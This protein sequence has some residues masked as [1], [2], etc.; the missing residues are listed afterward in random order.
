MTA[1]DVTKAANC[2]KGRCLRATEST[3]VPFAFW[4]FSNAFYALRC[5]MNI[6]ELSLNKWLG[7]G[8]GEAERR[9][10]GKLPGLKVAKRKQNNERGG[11]H[12]NRCPA[13]ADS[14]GGCLLNLSA[15]RAYAYAW[16]NVLLAEITLHA[17]LP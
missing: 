14:L 3:A 12:A 10:V 8:V 17:G 4:L 2:T 16:R 11:G 15:I 9:C 7:A 1:F 5:H 6:T 13:S